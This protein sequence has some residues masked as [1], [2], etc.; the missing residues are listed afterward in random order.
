MATMAENTA[1]LQTEAA[2]GRERRERIPPGWS[3]IG[4]KEFADH[5]LGVRFLLLFLVLGLV[6]A[7]VVYTVAGSIRDVADDATGAPGLFLFLFTLNP[8]ATSQIQLPPFAQLVGFLGP[9]LGI[10][11]GFDAISSER[12]EGTLPRL[13]S[14][15]VHRDDVINGKF[16]AGLSVIALILVSVVVLIT[17]VGLLR[18][19]LV[20]SADDVIRLI[21]WTAMTVVYIGFWLALATLASVVFRRAATAAL[22][23]LALWLVVTIF[24][25]TI[26]TFVANLVAPTG[27]SAT[28]QEALNNA[29]WEQNIS[30]LTPGQLFT[31]MSQVLLNPQVR[32]VDVTGLIQLQTPGSAAVGTVLPVDQSLLIIWPQMVALIAM[33]VICFAIAYIVF[34]RQ[35]V[36]A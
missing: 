27:P 19:S 11:F 5:V 17:A 2:G 4:G 22:V 32:T 25:S 24:G 14:Q 7:G 31:E 3:V 10:A 23:V 28:F 1:A 9:L 15:P 35:E 29:V 30:R 36:R 8:S 26:I 16:L 33:T 12:A 18:L 34:M 13:L 6:G 21:V 20:P